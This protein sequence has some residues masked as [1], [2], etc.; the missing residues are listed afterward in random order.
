MQVNKYILIAILVLLVS[1]CVESSN[2]YTSLKNYTDSLENYIQNQN[3]ELDETFAIMNEIEEGLKSIREGENIIVLKSNEN[4]SQAS[5]ENLKNDMIIIKNVITNY[6]EQIEK[7]K[8]SNKLNSKQF[9]KRLGILEK[10]L[11]EKSAI[12][13]ELTKQLEIKDGQLIVKQQQIQNL[14]KLIN[15][16]QTDMSNLNK[17]SSGLKDKVALQEKELY[18]S[19]YIVGTKPELIEAGVMTKGGLFKS[20]KISYQAE[21]D[22]FIKI[23]YREITEINTNSTKAKV[24]SIHPKGTY[25]LER[26]G[27]EVILTISNPN[28]FWEQTKYLVIQTQ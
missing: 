21:K 28:E 12:I 25:A 26:V 7:L 15:S 8:E 6:Q 4:I 3:I 2:K 23:D 14:D 11:K 1:S 5:R 13:A 17:E 24:L 9:N 27:E 19:Y 16:L 22:S 18:S 20:A 10:E